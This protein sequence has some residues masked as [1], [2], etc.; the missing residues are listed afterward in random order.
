MP[1][2]RHHRRSPKEVRGAHIHRNME[3]L[4]MGGSLERSRQE[5]NLKS[6]AVT[7][8]LDTQASISAELR[9]VEGGVQDDA[10]SHR[11]HSMEGRFDVWG[12]EVWQRATRGRP[13]LHS[14]TSSVSTAQRHPRRLRRLTLVLT[15][16]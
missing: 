12:D 8:G 13:F 15:Q 1:V 10:A 16:V 2:T 6:K 7:L 4:K 5:V 9:K 14:A 11:R 3:A